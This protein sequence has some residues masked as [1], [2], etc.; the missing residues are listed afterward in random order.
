M[1]LKACAAYGYD[2]FDG[3]G[4]AVTPDNSYGNAASNVV[5]LFGLYPDH[6][7]DGLPPGAEIGY[8]PIYI[9]GI[10]TRSGGKD[11]EIVGMGMG[12]GET[13]VL[14]RV[15]QVPGRIKEQIDLFQQTNPET[16]IRR[17]EFDI[18]GFSR[19]AAAARF[20]HRKPL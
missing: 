9:E 16:S 7:T 17:V 10:G 12:R 15:E 4:F 19:G 11:D 13:G 1:I 8:V 20:D 6:A 3:S 14:A 2:Q 5:H 18:F